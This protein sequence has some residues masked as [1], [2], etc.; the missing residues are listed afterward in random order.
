MNWFLCPRGDSHVYAEVPQGR[1]DVYQRDDGRGHQ[2]IY[3]SVKRTGCCASELR[4]EAP[5][6][7]EAKSAATFAADSLLSPAPP[8]KDPA[9]AAAD[10]LAAYVLSDG[11]EIDRVQAKLWAL[12]YQ[13]ARGGPMNEATIH[14][15]AR[16]FGI[17]AADLTWT[18]TSRFERGPWDEK[19]LER[20]RYWLGP[21]VVE[22]E[23]AEASAMA[24][25]EELLAERA[26]MRRQWS[27]ISNTVGDDK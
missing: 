7:E 8:A 24:R 10:E 27:E 4:D 15:R 25:W 16:T 13:Q 14:E 2:T 22:L 11:D 1:L 12:K 6:L 18:L 21:N 5:S 17:V 20:V 9:L 19:V 26:D 3:W 23:I